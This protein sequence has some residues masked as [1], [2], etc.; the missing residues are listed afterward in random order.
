MGIRPADQLNDGELALLDQALRSGDSKQWFEQVQPPSTPHPLLTQLP[1]YDHEEELAAV[2]DRPTS[3]Y[4]AKATEY[5][6]ATIETRQSVR[7]DS[8]RPLSELPEGVCRRTTR[9]WV[10][11]YTRESIPERSDDISRSKADVTQHGKYLFFTP[12]ETG[13][14]E[15]IVIEQFPRR[16]FSSAK[17]PTDPSRRSDAVL[18]LYFQDDRYKDDLRETY[19]NE[20]GSWGVASPFD[21][22]LPIIMPRGFKT[23]EATRQGEYSSKFKR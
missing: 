4:R 15:R 17:V 20:E 1:D 14:L 11:Y 10:W 12:D 13:V 18:C 7:P 5:I 21:P 9:H 23:D 3:T 8:L 16:P 6:E 22:D 2:P 19:Q